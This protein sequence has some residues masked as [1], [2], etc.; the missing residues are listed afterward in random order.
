M[1]HDTESR[2]PARPNGGSVTEGDAGA[3]SSMPN[4]RSAVL[5]TGLMLFVLFLVFG[6]IL[7]RFVDYQDVFEALAALTLAQFALMTAIGVIAWFACGQLFT[8]LVEGLSPLRGMTAYLILSGMGPSLPFG[9]WNLGV[10]WVVIRGWGHSVEQATSSVALYG[11]I[12]TLARFAMPLVALVVIVATGQLGGHGGAAA[13]ITVISIAIFFVAT[14]V[15]IAVV[16]SDRAAD[17]L[18]VHIQEWVS[19]LLAR[20][21]RTERPDVDGSI[22]RFRDS[23][24]EIVHRRGLLALIVTVISQIPWMIAFIVALRLTG[25]PGDVLTPADVIAVFA[26]VSVITII[27]ISPG[28]AGVPELLYIAGLTS[29]AGPGWEAAIT[30]GVFLFRLYVWFLPIPIAWVL[31]KVVRRGRPILPTTVEL[32]A[33][34][35]AG[36]S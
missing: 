9:P 33:Y 8:V 18:G 24:G 1:E 21:R 25:V 3:G 11:I 10:V 17:W 12:N 14:A 19:W 4:R 15:M 2:S 34:A 31:L 22:H 35:A 26:L 30:A 27:P 7:P 36:P 6:V 29:I 28:G 32:R 13:L 5:R 20:L 16:R 23:L